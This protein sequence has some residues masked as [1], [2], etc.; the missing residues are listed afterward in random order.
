MP[1]ISMC[2]NNLCVLKET[3]YRFKAKPC[4]YMQSYAIFEEIKGKCKYYWKLNE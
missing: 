4:K 1:D 2:M 3:C